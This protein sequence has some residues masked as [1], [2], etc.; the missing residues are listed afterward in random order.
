MSKY[1]SSPF[2]PNGYF[3]I[4]ECLYN[5]G[6]LDEA[7]QFYAY[8]VQKYPTSYKVE[9][10]RY[11][12]SLSG[13]KKREDELLKLLQWSYEDSL[14]LIEEFQRRDQTY[15]QAIISYQK[16][17]AGE[18]IESTDN[19]T[20]AKFQELL[21]EKDAEIM[22]LKD[23]NDE[24]RLKAEDIEDLENQ[25]AD[26]E[27]EIEDLKQENE[28]LKQQLASIQESGTTTV[29]QAELEAQKQTLDQMEELLNLKKRALEVKE[30]YLKWLESYLEG[31]Q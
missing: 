12:I 16:M 29:T 5:L 9:A 26:M 25:V 18:G 21:T 17:L 30:T 8:V 2:I 13:F 20:I 14:K 28:D 19:E 27:Q 22:A 11:R 10:A 7:L 4:G 1:R 3:F 6:Q 24:L 15:E 31:Q 23:E